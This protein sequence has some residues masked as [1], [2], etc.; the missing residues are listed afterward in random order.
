[1]ILWFAGGACLAVLLVFGDSRID[2]RLVVAGALLPDLPLRLTPLHSLLAP[3]A[4]ML[5]VMLVARRRLT[6]R[7]LLAVPIG[8]FMH[9]VLDGMWTR[10]HVFWWPLFGWS[11]AGGRLPSLDRPVWALAVEEAVGLA[12][13]L[14]VFAS[15]PP[16][17]TRSGA[18]SELQGGEGGEGPAC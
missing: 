10:A 1:V 3:V 14:W 18:D 7:R 5:A 4:L 11:A 13:L 15:R 16:I 9:L 17:R 12:A 8:M 2:Y 6:Q